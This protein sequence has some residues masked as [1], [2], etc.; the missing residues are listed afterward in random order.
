MG[1]IEFRMMNEGDFDEIVALMVKGF[2]HSTLYTWAAPD[3]TE[4]LKILNSMFR[5]RVSSWPKGAF[6]TELALDGDKIVGSS[7]WVPPHIDDKPGNGSGHRSLD[8]VLKGLSPEVVE[9]WMKF[10]PV[11]EAQDKTIPQPFWDLAPIAV[12]PEAQGKG[13]GS[14]L[15]WRKLKEIDQAAQPCFLATQDRINLGIYE[16]FGFKKI[17]E[18]LVAPGGPVSYSMLRAP[19]TTFL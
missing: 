8:E 17:D 18:I 11:I 10:Q 9:R 4:R 5:H 15:L 13:I 3:E 7:T 16:R 12:A 14:Q 19:L 1:N 2:F 6:Q